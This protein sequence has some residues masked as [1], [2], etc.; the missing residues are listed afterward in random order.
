MYFIATPIGN[1]GDIS[2]RAIDVLSQVDTICAEDTRKTISLLRLLNIADYK[3]K[4][5]IS[6][7]EHNW[8]S[9]D[10]IPRILAL[11]KTDHSIAVVSDAGTPG[12]LKIDFYR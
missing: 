5:I 7:H 12:E 9:N 10:Q 1:L 3:K 8:K 6:H 2:R 11:I 4:N